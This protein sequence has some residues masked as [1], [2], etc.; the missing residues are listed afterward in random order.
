MNKTG[1]NI[2]L[3][4]LAAVFGPA[5]LVLVSASLWWARMYLAPILVGFGFAY[6]LEPIVRWLER[7]GL[8][9]QFGVLLLALVFVTVLVVTPLVIV[10]MAQNETQQLVQSFAEYYQVVEDWFT[11]AYSS[12]FNGK[13][14]PPIIESARVK[15]TENLNVWLPQ[16]LSNTTSAIVASVGAIVLGVLLATLATFYLLVDFGKVKGGLARLV[17]KRW[18]P[19]VVDIAHE[20]DG[21]IGRYIR[22]QLTMVLM[23]AILATVALTIIGGF[24][25]TKYALVC[26]LLMGITALIPA[27][28]ITISCIVAGTVAYFTAEHHAWTAVL[29]TVLTLV[30]IN[31]IFD[32][33]V[34]PRIVGRKVGLHPLVSLLA[35]LIG[36]AAFGFVGVLLA[37]PV[38]ASVKVAIERFYKQEKEADEAE[39]DPETAS[40]EKEQASE[41]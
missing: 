20:V 37:V 15:V 21:V 26:G 31:F 2:L 27:I 8:A 14:I 13:E 36:G 40:G 7:C 35:V 10:P 32:N 3:G 33:L 11:E 22:G 19:R 6:L 24:Y 30:A 28:G 39:T 41:N 38:V 9:R 29:V 5:L 17:P 23:V 25:G 16:W 12:Y 4:T 18:R 1:R 34:T